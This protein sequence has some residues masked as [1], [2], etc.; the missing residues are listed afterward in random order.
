MHREIR[1]LICCIFERAALLRDSN[2][3]LFHTNVIPEKVQAEDVDPSMIVSSEEAAPTG[4][5][6]NEAILQ[7]Q[8][9]DADLSLLT[10]SD[11]EQIT[12]RYVQSCMYMYYSVRVLTYDIVYWNLCRLA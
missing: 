2:V 4:T 10:F 6:T 12:Y 11:T 1:E 7:G 5:P 3:F 9:Q 8:R